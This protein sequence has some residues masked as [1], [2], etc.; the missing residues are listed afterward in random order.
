MFDAAIVKPWR[1]SRCG[2][3]LAAGPGEALGTGS[4]RIAAQGMFILKLLNNS[5][6]SL[7]NK[8]LDKLK[9]EVYVISNL[10]SL[11]SCDFTRL[12]LLGKTGM[13]KNNYLFQIG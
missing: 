7:S 2:L 8:Q 11:D 1:R 9:L 6:F 5:N 10:N 4:I 3:K 12:I 13:L